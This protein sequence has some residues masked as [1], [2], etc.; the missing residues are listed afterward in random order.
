MNEYRNTH[1]MLSKTLL[2]LMSNVIEIDIDIDK[3]VQFIKSQYI[4]RINLHD[5]PFLFR[6]DFIKMKSDLERLLEKTIPSSNQNDD[7]YLFNNELIDIYTKLTAWIAID[8]YIEN[9]NIM[10]NSNHGYFWT[11]H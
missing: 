8:G 9:Q 1:E 3:K 7:F 6:N 2:A 10:I 5:I 4:A 11:T